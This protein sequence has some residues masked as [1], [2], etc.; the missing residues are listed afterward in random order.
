MRAV[1]QQGC[2]AVSDLFRGWT[3][4]AAMRCMFRCGASLPRSTLVLSRI[5]CSYR[6]LTWLRR[7]VRVSSQLWAAGLQVQSITR[8]Q[9]TVPQAR[10]IQGP[11]VKIWDLDTEELK[12][13]SIDPQEPESEL[14][15]GSFGSVRVSLHEPR[16]LELLI[17]KV[18]LSLHACPVFP[19]PPVL[20]CSSEHRASWRASRRCWAALPCCASGEGPVGSRS[21]LNVAEFGSNSVVC[22]TTTRPCPHS[23]L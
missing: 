10:T 7:T 20:E 1:E 4:V 9:S 19:N 14:G 23:S 17:R 12:L 6:A 21:M 5:R 16:A 22:S 13:H 2:A 18:E 11:E 3:T 8:T 15:A